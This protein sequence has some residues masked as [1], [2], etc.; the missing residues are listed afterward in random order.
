M[1]SLI[2]PLGPVGRVQADPDSHP[3]TVGLP[4]IPL[5]QQHPVELL[6]AWTARGIMPRGIFLGD[7]FGGLTTGGVDIGLVLAEDPGRDWITWD[8]V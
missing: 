3:L 5:G 6:E 7:D 2:E 4:P 1:N 8:A